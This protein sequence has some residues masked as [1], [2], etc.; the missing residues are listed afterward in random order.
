MTTRLAHR[1][2]PRLAVLVETPAVALVNLG[3]LALL[4]AALPPLLDWAVFSAVWRADDMRGCP[5]AGGACWAFIGD[6]ARLIFFGLY[7][8][9]EQWRA[10][11]ATALLVALVVV[12]LNPRCWSRRLAL[13][14]GLGLAVYSLLMWGGL[15]GLAPVESAY[16]GGLPLTVLL[17]VFGVFFG[18]ILAVPVALARFSDL[19][20]FKAAATLYVELVRG[21]PLIS[22]LFMASVLLPIFLPDG[23]TPS[24]L[25]RVLAGIVLFFTAYM[26]EVLR[27]GL[28]AIPRGQYE[29]SRSLGLSYPV[30]MARVVLPQAFQTI[31]PALINLIIAALKGTSLVVIVAML[32]LLGAAQAA[33]ADPDWIGFYVEDYVFV[34]A[35]Y[36]IMCGSI[37]WYGR[38]VERNLGSAQSR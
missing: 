31:L 9:G 32:D 25:G 20:V 28:Q 5:P 8:Y 19:P 18:L 23:F 11:L 36:A 21:V 2:P 26:A 24:G 14:W 37:S 30:M 1:L 34:A 22:V 13:A 7:P 17:T 6:K 35:V 4:V 38:R 3:V 10:A 15:L 16:W 27:G 33:L 12:S 29:A